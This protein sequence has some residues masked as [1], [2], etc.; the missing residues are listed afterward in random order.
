MADLIP[1]VTPSA[2][3]VLER[4]FLQL[5]AKLLE[6]AAQLD[7]L[8]RAA[9]D[10]HDEP[11]MQGIKKALAELAGTE[12]TRAERVQIIFSRQYDARWKKKMELEQTE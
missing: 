4:E 2:T 5:R 6:I 8:D 10:V 1:P 3:D 9:G 11:R 7:R 12:P